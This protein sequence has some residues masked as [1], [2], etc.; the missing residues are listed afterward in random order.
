[1]AEIGRRF[2]L[3]KVH[4]D[5]SLKKA[6]KLMKNN[7]TNLILLKKELQDKVVKENGI[8]MVN[9]KKVRKLVLM[10]MYMKENGIVMVHFYQERKLILMEQYQK[11]NGIEKEKVWQKV[12]SQNNIYHKIDRRRG[13]PG[14]SLGM[15][16]DQP[17]P[18]SAK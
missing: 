5:P 18:Q 9:L 13:V 2:S 16:W 10:D 17:Y 6:I 8:V 12:I 4:V 7:L 14:P 11:E 15:D 3:D 1:M